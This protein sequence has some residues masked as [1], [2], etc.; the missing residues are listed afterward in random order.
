MAKEAPN[1]R[2]RDYEDIIAHIR[3]VVAAR[4]LAD[5]AGEI[6]E[7]HV[8]A[9]QRRSARQVTRDIESALLSRFGKSIDAKRVSVAQIKDESESALLPMRLMLDG[10]GFRTDGGTSEARVALRDDD[11]VNEGVVSG[12]ASSA[13]RPRLVAAA[14]L[15]AVA[16]HFRNSRTFAVEDVAIVTLGPDL[17][18]LVG[19]TPVSGRGRML[20]GSSLVRRDEFEA[21]ARATLDALNRQL[22]FASRQKAWT[23]GSPSLPVSEPSGAKL[24]KT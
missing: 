18:A 13:N 1:L 20:V 16:G 3:D 6:L 7:I 14:T 22:E 9:R 10:I 12:P 19:V 4:V 21:I 24:P 11:N 15:A 17:V 23:G 5:D 2:T 8:L